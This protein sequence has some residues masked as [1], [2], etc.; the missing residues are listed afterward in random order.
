MKGILGLAMLLSVAMGASGARAATLTVAVAASSQESLAKI[1]QRFE[2]ETHQHVELISGSSGKLVA[3][4]L[5][6]AP[7]DLLFA[8]DSFYPARLVA[9]GQVS[10]SPAIYAR[11]KVALCVPRDLGLDLRHGLSFVTDPRVHQVAIANPELAPYGRLAL[12]EMTRNHAY[13]TLKGKL[14][15][16]DDVAQVAQFFTTRAVS[17]AFMPSSLVLSPRVQQL[18]PFQALYSQ[19]PRTLEMAA[20]VMKRSPNQ[21]LARNFLSYCSSPEAR[22]IWRRYGL[23]P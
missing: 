17:L 13:D 1:A 14:I 21:G 7:M 18:R 5:Q 22:V 8:A 11:G 3:Q 12:E 9:A 20:V 6:G 2:R 15:Y 16:G 10:G 4:I 23:A 19:A